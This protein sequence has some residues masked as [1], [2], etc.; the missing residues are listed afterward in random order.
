M[1]FRRFKPELLIRIMG[2]TLAPKKKSKQSL[3]SDF[4]DDNTRSVEF[5]HFIQ[6]KF[7]T[8]VFIGWIN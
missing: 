1:L 7:N 2:F 6:A 5:R 4:N 8:K 3:Q